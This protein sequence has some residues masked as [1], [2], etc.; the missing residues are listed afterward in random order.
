VT[1]SRFIRAVG[2]LSDELLG[3]INAA[4]Q[5]NK[6]SAD[7]T[8]YHYNA[9]FARVGYNWNDTY[10]VNLTARRDGSSRFGPD[11]RFA[12]FGAIGIA[13]IFS[14]ERFINDKLH[15]LSF[16]KLRGSYGTTGNDQIGDYGFL[17]SYNA[18]SALYQGNSILVPTGLANAAYAWEINRKMEMGLDVVFFR[19]RIS[20]SANFYR[21]E[22]ANQLVGYSLPLLTGFGS[23]QANLDATVRNSG[24]ELIVKSINLKSD[25]FSWTT[26]INFT[27]PRNKL[28]SYPNLKGSSYASTY[29]VGKPL[30]ILKVYHITGTNTETGFYQF[31]DTDGNN[32]INAED[33][34]T[35]INIGRQYYG[36]IE[37]VIGYKKFQIGLFAEFVRQRVRGY[38]GTFLQAPGTSM[39]Q[40][41]FVA[42]E[43]RWQSPGDVTST[44]KFTNDNN[45]YNL[46]RN[47][48]LNVGEGSFVRMK[49]VTLSYELPSKWT[50]RMHLQNGTV[51]IHAQNLFL[52]TRY[53]GLDPEIPGNSQMPQ[54]RV[55]TAGLKLKI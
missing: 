37:N 6:L 3:N 15:G 35:V 1:D 11:N 49:T 44:Q 55:L 51:F 29:Q 48:D 54:L 30:T 38:L 17:S 4:P 16:A 28:M 20:L 42:N 18:S 19:D 43:P 14:N 12:N 23:V 34:Q 25:D 53:K 32:T 27:A 7:N 40:P 39:N 52:I 9:L 50:Q 45:A 31:L 10:F 21:N 2:Y 41:A 22:S 47:S 26:S 33:R 5:I 46:A 24:M 13:W 36:G 8:I